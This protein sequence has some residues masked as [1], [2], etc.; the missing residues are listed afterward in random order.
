MFL[1][2]IK[3]F[4]AFCGPMVVATPEMKSNCEE[5]ESGGGGGCIR[6][7]RL[8][9]ITNPSLYAH[10]HRPWPAVLYQRKTVYPG[11]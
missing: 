2:L 11:W 6:A 4:K 1:G 3:N 5:A 10:V 9:G 8:D 7:H